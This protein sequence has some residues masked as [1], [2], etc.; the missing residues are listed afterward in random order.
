MKLLII[1][2]LV[3]PLA[4]MNSCKEDSNP[5][6][7]D[8]QITLSS[9]SPTSGYSNSQVTLY[10]KNFL[11][12]SLVNVHFGD[13]PAKIISQSNDSIVVQVPDS[14]LGEVKII[15]YYKHAIFIYGTKFEV[16]KSFFDYSGL[17]K[18]EILFNNLHIIYR[19]YY[20]QRQNIE[21]PSSSDISKELFNYRQTFKSQYNLILSKM[22]LNEYYM[23]T[24]SN[25]YSIFKLNFKVDELNKKI[26]YLDFE[27]KAVT[28][29]EQTP[30]I[31]EYYSMKLYLNNVATEFYPDSLI[32]IILSGKD[33]NSFIS[34]LY[35]SQNGTYYYGSKFSEYIH[36]I[37]QLLPS[38]D[39]TSLT[40]KIYK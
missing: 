7:S 39:S 2:A 1:L 30:S 31:Q 16:K 24:S 33:M 36:E 32:L 29:W 23:S 3:L 14:L 10:G 17:S 18:Y 13:K 4:L 15:I 8:N 6:P 9:F 25:Y 21:P 40:I 22:N 26:I 35:F 5:L 19:D 34:N 28:R 12:D 27:I 11:S 37:K 20:N 38:T